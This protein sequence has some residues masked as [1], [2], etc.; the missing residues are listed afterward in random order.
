MEFFEHCYLKITNTDSDKFF[1]TC[2]QFWEDTPKHIRASD[3]KI[4][5]KKLED[6]VE[7]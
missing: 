1:K 5:L 6:A 2:V 3:F 4:F 7:S